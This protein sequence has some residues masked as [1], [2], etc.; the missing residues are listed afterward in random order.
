VILLTLVA[1]VSTRAG[2][3]GLTR[4][5]LADADGGRLLLGDVLRDGERLTLTWHNSLFDQPVREVFYAQGGS[6]VEDEVTFI[7]PQGAYEMPVS[8]TDVADLYHTGGAFS[9]HG[10]N[11]PFGQIIFRIGEIGDLHVQ[12]RG[13]S[14]ALKQEVGFGGRV[15]LST[16][17]P[18]AVEALASF[19]PRS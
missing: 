15:R 10:L 14:I 16:H 12:V 19:L 5:E 4:L 18:T 17:R 1:A 2:L 8:A 3:P 9:A 11:R 13:R 7:D 6:L